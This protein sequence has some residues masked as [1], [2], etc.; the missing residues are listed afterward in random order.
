MTS[1]PAWYFTVRNIFNDPEMRTLL[2]E[3][4]FMNSIAMVGQ[5]SQEYLKKTFLASGLPLF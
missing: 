2:F 5:L 3:K 4:H 1:K